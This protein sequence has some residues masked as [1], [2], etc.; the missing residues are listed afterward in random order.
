MTSARDVATPS[1]AARTLAGRV[2]PEKPQP[3]LT[4]DIAACRC[5]AHVRAGLH[6]LNGDWEHAHRIAQ[7]LEDPVGSHWHAL[8]HRHEPDFDN[9]KY[10]LARVGESPVYAALAAAARAANHAA[11]LRAGRWDAARFTDAYAAD[12]PTGWTRTLDR[13]ER[14]ALLEYCLAQTSDSHG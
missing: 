10:W 12:S 9:S 14:R 8:V 7:G 3:A 5:N 6:L 11:V 2:D 1:S 4:A 13:L